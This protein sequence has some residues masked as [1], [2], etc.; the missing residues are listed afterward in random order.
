LQDAGYTPLCI[1]SEGP[2]TLQL[3]LF[4][5][6]FPS[7]GGHEFY[8]SY[9]T[10]NEAPDD[11]LVNESLDYLL[12][13][14]PYFNADANSLGWDAGVNHMLDDDAPCAMTVMGDWAK[15]HLV[16]RGWV[17]GQDFEQIP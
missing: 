17:P 9:W 5:N 1:G 4:E 10:G 6:I 12:E 13:L 2:W 14:W 7:V 8:T 11:D 3:L 16:S 15:G